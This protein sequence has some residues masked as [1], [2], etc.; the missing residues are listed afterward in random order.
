MRDLLPGVL[1]HVLR[2]LRTFAGVFRTLLLYLRE[3]YEHSSEGSRGVVFLIVIVAL[4]LLFNHE[5]I[6]WRIR[7]SWPEALRPSSDGW[8]NDAEWQREDWFF[9]DEDAYVDIVDDAAFGTPFESFPFIVESEECF[10]LAHAFAFQHL[11]PPYAFDFMN[12][13]EYG[14]EYQAWKRYGRHDT[15]FRMQTMNLY[16]FPHYE[17]DGDEGFL[18]FLSK[19][20]TY[21]TGNRNLSDAIPDLYLGPELTGDMRAIVEK[22]VFAPVIEEPVAHDALVF[23]VNA[24]NPVSGLTT[25]ELRGIYAGEIVSWHEV[26]GARHKIKA[27]QRST[28][29]SISQQAMEERVM[30]GVSMMEPPQYRFRITKEQMAADYD[31]G[32]YS[33]GYTYYSYLDRLYPFDDE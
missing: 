9:P 32:K 29:R 28:F 30:K 15:D 4:T 6:E 20:S 17:G 22:Q 16:G 27:F 10:A 18:L 19:T 3:R 14:G 5:K 8:R 25:R 1:S 33:I 26:G 13:D 12:R 24:E 2:P 11:S 21:R 31:N 23:L 7:D